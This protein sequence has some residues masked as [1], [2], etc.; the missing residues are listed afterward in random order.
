[1]I[2]NEYFKHQSFYEEKY[3]S[4]TIVLMMIGSFY[5]AY[6]TDAIGKCY[7]LSQLLN[8]VVTRKDKNKPGEP[9]VS[10]PLMIGIPVC[11]F[12]KYVRVLMDNEFH[13]VVF[14][15]DVK[16][17]TIRNLSRIFSPGTYVEDSSNS[18]SHYIG[19]VY[20]EYSDMM[21]IGLSFADLSTGET[22]T[23]EI[24]NGNHTLRIEELYRLVEF[25]NPCETVFHYSS[26]L[27]PMHIDEIKRLFSSRNTY[28]R[29][30]DTSFAKIDYQN[31]IINKVFQCNTVLTP[32]EYLDLELTNF[33]RTSFVLLLQYCYEHN[34]KCAGGFMKPSV[35]HDSNS[36]V[37]HNNSIY[38]LGVYLNSTDKSLFNVVNKTSTPMGK[39][40]LRLQLVNPCCN[41][42]L[43][44]QYHHDIDHMMPKFAFYE[45]KLNAIIDVERIQKKV[46]L[47]IC[48]PLDY[49][50]MIDSYQY[51][52]PLLDDHAEAFAP[53]VHKWLCEVRECV[54]LDKCNTSD[55]SCNLLC[56]A[57][58]SAGLKKLNTDLEECRR[59][60]NNVCKKLSSCIQNSDV[61]L[62]KQYKTGYFI[63][64]TKTRGQ[65]IKQQLP[66]EFTY[67][68]DKQRCI[69]T[70]SSIE[71]TFHKMF[72]L[73]DKIKP[74]ATDEFLTFVLDIQ[75]KY[76]ECIQLSHKRIAY[77]DTIKSRIKCTADNR[78]TKPNISDG[79]SSSICATELRHPIIDS[80]DNVLY[81]PNNVN[82]S[83]DSRG[84]LLYGVNGSGKS[85]YS[86]AIGLCI[87]LAQS[88]HY[89]PAQTFDIC[90]F[91]RMYTRIS[92]AD[93]I[94]KGQSSFFVE[95]SELKSIIHYAD[96]KSIILGDEVC[97]GTED[98]SGVAI[99][100]SSV[101]WLLD[102]NA[103]FIF[104]THL[105][106]LST[107]SCINKHPNLS[108]KHMEVECDSQNNVITFKRS[109][110][111]GIGDTL[112]G[113]EI[114]NYIIQHEEFS[115]LTTKNRNEVLK[116]KPKLVTNKKSRYNQS[117]IVD[118]CQIPE[119]AM[120]DELESHHIV[121]QSSADAKKI[122]VHN[123]NN[124]VVLCKTHHDAV[125]SGQLQIS[126]WK[127]TTTGKKLDFTYAV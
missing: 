98:T 19:C 5:E 21:Y 41:K 56:D 93:N 71:C 49:F 75:H 97:K 35:H 27:D 73:E 67:K 113:V 2:V 26:T 119:C 82:L 62:E 114:A 123:A 100:A 53:N 58:T 86:K 7:E 45:Q 76:I 61:K 107:M 16:D 37:L 110:K 34:H 92:D 3:G 79:D 50:T 40:L 18:N 66:T 81:V 109:M 102:H 80:M 101:K 83:H 30:F 120:T 84:L 47:R 99:V 44:E 28:Q 4:R 91:T 78:Y 23:C 64:T 63:S 124:L 95:M 89:V 127:S 55:I 117:I 115:K 118:H 20:F 51:I 74:L 103:K 77:Y 108:I 42:A 46:S 13:V 106:K 90:P 38:Q 94:Y 33:A 96:S 43:I 85:C 15:Q 31:A 48:S 87:V 32:I 122:N 10:N 8:L 9:S 12:K 65:Q 6:G 29:D 25:Y 126:G 39:R 105:H 116:K 57:H 52:T 24:I 69:I 14:D 36:L 104:A 1:M 125:H 59:K 121:F 70:N 22:S 68:V 72:Q 112:Y 54:L 11:A 88:G 17:P 111:D 60:I